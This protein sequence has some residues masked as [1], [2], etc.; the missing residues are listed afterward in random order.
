MRWL[1]PQSAGQGAAG[2]GEICTVTVNGTLG[3]KVIE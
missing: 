2:I 3:N 1:T